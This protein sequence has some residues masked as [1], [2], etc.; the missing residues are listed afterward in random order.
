M[1]KG[2]AIIVQARADKKHET[3]VGI[4]I[5][6]TKAYW[7]Y[8]YKGHVARVRKSTLWHNLDVHTAVSVLHGSS[9]KRRRKQRKWRSLDLHG[10]KHDS[11][12]EKVRKFLNF[13]E[14]PCKIITGDSDEMIK[15]V[16]KI[17]GEYNWQIS[18][19]LDNPGCLLVD[20][21]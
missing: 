19:T 2:D 9:M 10:V 20:E 1:R 7:Y 17:V 13:V 14:L 5:K 3:G 16:S 15:L 8:F 21:P 4:L 12:D 11:V 18:R 6:Q